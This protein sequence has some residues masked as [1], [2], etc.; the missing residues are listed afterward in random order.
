MKRILDESNKRENYTTNKI[1]KTSEYFNICI[2]TKSHNY[3][4][5]EILYNSVDEVDTVSEEMMQLKYLLGL[6]H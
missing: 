2:N 6:I 5:R 3:N 1:N 4:N